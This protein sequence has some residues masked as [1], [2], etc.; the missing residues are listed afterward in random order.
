MRVSARNCSSARHRARARVDQTKEKPRLGRLSAASSLVG[1]TSIVCSMPSGR[2]TTDDAAL[3]VLSIDESWFFGRGEGSA[4][5]TVDRVSIGQ[6]GRRSSILDGLHIFASEPNLRGPCSQPERGGG[7][8]A[9]A[10]HPVAPSLRPSS[11]GR[12]PR[13]EAP[14]RHPARPRNPKLQSFAER[15][16]AWRER[17]EAAAAAPPEAGKRGSSRVWNADAADQACQNGQPPFTLPSVRQH[18]V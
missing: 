13:H 6:D 16:K 10:Q 14:S 17:L 1:S 3:D 5:H 2:W 9:S 12:P 4:G 7:P 8:A 18:N 11:G 15:R